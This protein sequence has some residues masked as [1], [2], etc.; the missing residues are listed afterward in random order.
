MLH[1]LQPRPEISN[2][3]GKVFNVNAMFRIFMMNKIVGNLHASS[4]STLIIVLRTQMISRN[5]TCIKFL[6]EILVNSSKHNNY[7]LAK[8]YINRSDMFY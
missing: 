4:V 2:D 7:M 1:I 5:L 8:Y 6:I 3:S